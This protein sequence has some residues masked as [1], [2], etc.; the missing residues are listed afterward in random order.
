MGDESEG[1]VEGGIIAVIRMGADAFGEASEQSG[2]SLVGQVAGVAEC[3]QGDFRGL[4]ILACLLGQGGFRGEVGGFES[5]E[6]GIGSLVAPAGEEILGAVEDVVVS[7]LLHGACKG[8][9]GGVAGNR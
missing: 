5:G 6:G 8:D 9:C 4:D 2:E 3:A 7:E 1:A